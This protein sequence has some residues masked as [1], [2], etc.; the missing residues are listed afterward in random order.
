V[1]KDQSENDSTH[2]KIWVQEEH[3]Q[4]SIPL[5]YPNEPHTLEK[6]TVISLSC[7]YDRF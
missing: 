7:P 3:R 5:V 1:L 4:M 6:K 2:L